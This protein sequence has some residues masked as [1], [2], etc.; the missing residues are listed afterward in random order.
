MLPTVARISEKLLY[1]QLYKYFIDNKILGKTQWVFHS[2]YLTA[3]A[4]ANCTSDWFK[5]NIDKGHV[6][7]VVFL[8]IKIGF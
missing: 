6:N 5:M 1:D 4:L 3:L 8:D 7:T 2:S